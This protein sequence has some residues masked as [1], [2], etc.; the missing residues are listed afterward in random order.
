MLGVQYLFLPADAG[1]R[2]VREV[3]PLLLTLFPVANAIAAR[4]MIDQ[5]G[6]EQASLELAEQSRRLRLAMAAADEG[7]WDIDLVSGAVT[8]SAEAARLI[9]RG[10]GRVRLTSTECIRG[11]I[12]TIVRRMQRV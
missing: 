12:P 5:M 11:C 1:L 4:M 3:G 6:R 8:L 2:V 7:A 10:D 9:G